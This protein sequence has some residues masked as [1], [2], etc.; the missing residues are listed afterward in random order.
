MPATPPELLRLIA[1]LETITDLSKADRDALRAL[2]FRMRTIAERRDLIRE[3]SQPVES[4]LVV[5]GML[6]RYKMLSNGR[7]QILSFHFPG[8]MPDLQSLHLTNMDHSIASITPSKVALIP[9]EAVRDLARTTPTAAA[10]LAK[11][12]L[13]DS[14]ISREWVANIGRRTALERV[15]HLICECFVRQ[16]AIGLA[17][18]STFELPLTQSEIGDAMGLSN[19]HVNRTMRELRRLGLIET[20]GKV[21][22]I[23]DWEMLQETGDF[24]PA[25]L[26]LKRMA[27]AA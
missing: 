10:A 1:Q 15:A 23:S 11:H 21:H 24:D 16:R 6:C 22:G 13:I 8:D 20:N 7:R 2:P 27:P 12:G 17:K 9:H 5:E 25:Y 3:N 14:S 4:C 18:T 26:H 19:V